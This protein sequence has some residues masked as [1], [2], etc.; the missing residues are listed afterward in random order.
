MGL[1]QINEQ[2]E[3]LSSSIQHQFLDVAKELE[4]NEEDLTAWIELFDDLQPS[5]D[6]TNQKLFSNQQFLTLKKIKKLIAEEGYDLEQLKKILLANTTSKKTSKNSKNKK[7]YFETNNSQQSTTLD[8]SN[9]LI[10]NF[11]SEK[12]DLLKNNL[13]NNQDNQ[14]D[15]EETLEQ[16]NFGFTTNPAQDSSNDSL[17]SSSQFSLPDD[18][19][20]SH[21]FDICNKIDPT[22]KI[23]DFSNIKLYNIHPKLKEQLVHRLKC[24][25]LN[26]E[27]LSKILK[28]L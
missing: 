6:Q 19:N 16:R 7:H 17:P 15:L 3:K 26:V 12:Q 5:L 23:K 22:A 9:Q 4:I 28:N 13:T 14:E 25:N 2:L 10:I 1:E 11:S 27:E 18:V 8:E 24:L 21:D 20:H